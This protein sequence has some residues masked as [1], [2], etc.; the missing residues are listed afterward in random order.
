MQCDE[1]QMFDRS[2]QYISLMG[3]AI[4]FPHLNAWKR[5]LWIHILSTL[6]DF[7]LTKHG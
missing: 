3:E 2:L 4:G 1:Q 6:A 7:G 5:E